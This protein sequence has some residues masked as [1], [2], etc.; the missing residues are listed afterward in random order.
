MDEQ[1][2]A[3][4][5]AAMG[6]R[7]ELAT[8]EAPPRTVNKKMRAYFSGCIDIDVSVLIDNDDDEEELYKATEEK[9]DKDIVS[10]LTAIGAKEISL[11]EID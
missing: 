8:D 3:A 5:A 9:F 6:R 11:D 1:T 4:I 7:E 10:M 2:K